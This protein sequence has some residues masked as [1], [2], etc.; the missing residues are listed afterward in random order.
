VLFDSTKWV[1]ERPGLPDGL[2][3][4]KEGRIWATG[5]GGVYCFSPEGKVL[6]RL[7]TGVPTANC[8]FGDDGWLYITADMY[9][10][11]VKTNTSA[12]KK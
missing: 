9:L 10:A 1:K 11:R 6:G 4:D 2:A 5:P 3:V 7:N 12:A 8:K